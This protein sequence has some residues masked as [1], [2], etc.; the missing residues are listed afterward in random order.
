MISLNRPYNISNVDN[1]PISE[2]NSRHI[3]ITYSSR[4]GLNIIYRRLFDQ[5]GQLRVAVSPLTCFVALQPIVDNGHIPMFVDIDPLTFNM[6]HETLEQHTDVQVV[7]IIYLGGNPIQMDRV[8]NWA[9]NKNVILIED[10]AQAFGSTYNNQ[11]LGTFGDYAVYSAVKNVYAAMGGVLLTKVAIDY[12][13]T[14][15]ISK[16]VIIYKYLKR[17]L[18]QHT[19]H[20][21]Y[22]LWNVVYKTLL[23]LKEGN[24]DILGTSVHDLPNTE[25]DKILCLFANHQQIQQ[26]RIE[27]ANKLISLLDKEKFRIQQEPE[28]GVSNRN[29]VIICAP[30]KTAKEIIL[31]LRKKGIA[32]N[33]LTQSYINPYQEQIHNIKGSLYN[34][35]Q[36]FPHLLT[37]PC[38]PSLTNKE[39]QYIAQCVNLI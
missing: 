21:N 6:S 39:I 11:L 29:R 36:I 15:V 8:V 4:E 3:H 33:N 30:H 35:E 19:N 32:A 37:L 24:A 7:Q 13:A 17:W 18:E 1:S 23:T 26:K 12:T 31:A 16:S 20:H 27:N 5:Y 22:N 10:C 34:Y 38:S 25:K 28:G 14:S 9:N 2:W